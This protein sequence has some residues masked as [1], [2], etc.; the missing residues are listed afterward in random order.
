MED[1]R[2]YFDENFPVDNDIPS[3]DTRLTV[4]QSV[5]PYVPSVQSVFKF[6]GLAALDWIMTNDDKDSA[7]K[8]DSIKIYTHY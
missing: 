1:I 4:Q 2:Y 5:L 3:S 7:P 6:P 8:L